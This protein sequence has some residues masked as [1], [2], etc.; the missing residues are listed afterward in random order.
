MEANMAHNVIIE[1]REKISISGVS[2]VES[3]DEG[4]VC[5][6]TSKGYMI[7]KGDGLHAQ[8]LNLENGELSLVGEILQ[9]EYDDRQKK[10]G[11]FLSKLFG[12]G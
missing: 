4:M 6:Y 10:S 12:W 8:K 5:L 11:G 2:D 7:I 1:G 3:F 9:I